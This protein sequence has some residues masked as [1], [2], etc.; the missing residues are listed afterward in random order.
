MT[1]GKMRMEKC[2]QKVWTEK[3]TKIQKRHPNELKQRCLIL[4]NGTVPL[5][6]KKGKNDMLFNTECC[7]YRWLRQSVLN[8]L[9]K[10]SLYFRSLKRQSCQHRFRFI[11]LL[12]WQTLK[13]LFGKLNPWRENCSI[14]AGTLSALPRENR[15]QKGLPGQ[16]AS[17]IRLVLDTIH[18]FFRHG[19]TSNHLCAVSPLT[20]ISLLVCPL[21]VCKPFISLKS[22]YGPKGKNCC[23]PFFRF[24]I[25][26]PKDLSLWPGRRAAGNAGAS[27][28]GQDYNQKP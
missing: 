27:P 28:R 16:I 6:K 19:L 8:N 5:T 13:H 22:Q 26:G 24:S 9:E 12:G 7:P 3:N 2:R 4:L 21:T 14:V 10:S 1:D 20:P 18:Q 15:L 25:Q 17:L 23:Y 11:I